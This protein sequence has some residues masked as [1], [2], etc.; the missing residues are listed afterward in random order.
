MK[1]LAAILLLSAFALGQ[2]G[3]PDNVGTGLLPPGLGGVTDLDAIKQSRIDALQ[4]AVEALQS[5]YEHGLDNPNLLFGAQIELAIARLDA[6]NVK[7]ERLD[8]IQDALLAALLTWQRANALNKAGVRGG[9][10]ATETQARAAVFRYRV[11]WL[12][13]KAGDGN[14]HEALRLAAMGQ[15]GIPTNVGT[16]LLPPG[17]GGDTDLDGIKQSRIDA[18][19]QAVQALQAQYES[20]LDNVGYLLAAHEELS[21]AR[22]DATNV[23]QERLEV[24]HDALLAAL[25]TWQR[26]KELQKNGVRGGD[27]AAEAQTRVAVFR[28]QF[29]WLKEK[30]GAGN[31]SKALGPPGLGQGGIL[32]SVGTGLL[33]PGLDR[34]TELH[35]IKQSRIDALQNEVQ[36]LQAR[37]ESGLD[38]MGYLFAA[39]EELTFA[40]LD[41]TNVKQERLDSIQ[42]ALRAALLTWQRAKELQKAGVRG[43]D[44]ATEIQARAAVFRYR[45]MWLKEKAGENIQPMALCLPPL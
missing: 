12:K 36:A 1:L 20:G 41:A 33:P 26:V 21:I 27:A 23:I 34:D 9:D 4:E 5:R 45:V 8:F 40:R 6:T 39:H 42:D 44:A 2:E 35:A 22:L 17:L 11:M 14:Q 32:E 38:N 16:G 3:V 29:M 28:C 43:G 13:E 18:S 19:Q 30:A 24:I 15:E 7:K 10:S 37:Y 25:L 31:Q